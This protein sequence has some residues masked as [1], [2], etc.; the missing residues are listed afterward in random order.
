MFPLILLVAKELA[1]AIRALVRAIVARDE[2]AAKIA[3]SD[4]LAASNKLAMKAAR[5]EN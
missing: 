5:G 2:R 3:F 1:P 4:A